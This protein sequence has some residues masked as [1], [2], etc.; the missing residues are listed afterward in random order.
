[1]P[2]PEKGD[3]KVLG[4]D[5]PD[6]YASWRSGAK[7]AYALPLPNGRYRVTLHLFDPVE[8]AAGKRVFTVAAGSGKPVTVDVVAKAGAGMTATTLELPAM[9]TDGV[10]TLAF[11]GKTGEALVS[12]IDV[13][14]E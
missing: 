14:G 4:T 8:T 11:E 5:Q 6:L 13:V 2:K 12:A 7:F 1:M 10:L 3:R 9:V